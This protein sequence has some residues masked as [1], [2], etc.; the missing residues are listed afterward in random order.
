M[1]PTNKTMKKCK[2][3]SRRTYFGCVW[4]F[5]S[6][7]AG[8][9]WKLPLPTLLLVDYSFTE[10]VSHL[11]CFSPQNFFVVPYSC[12]RKVNLPL[13]RV[14][15]V[16]F[17]SFASSHTVSDGAGSEL[18][19]LALEAVFLGTSPRA[20]DLSTCH[21]GSPHSSTERLDPSF[22]ALFSQLQNVD[23]KICLTGWLG[24]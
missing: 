2:M 18:S 10:K 23:N 5:S 13:S 11:T 7:P 9:S 24:H 1:N 20:E 14:I 8:H 22:L 12:L 21:A 15:T 17:K 4:G 16:I 3:W 6:T 19:G